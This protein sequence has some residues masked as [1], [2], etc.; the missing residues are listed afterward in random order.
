MKRFI[1]I[2]MCGAMVMAGH[3]SSAK[4]EMPIEGTLPLSYGYGAGYCN[5]Y[6]FGVGAAPYWLGSVPTPPYFALHPPVY[7]SYAV[8][9]TFGHSPFPY[10]GTYRTPEVQPAQPEVIENP[11]VEPEKDN[12][13]LPLENTRMTT[14]QVGVFFNPFVASPAV[15]D[16]PST[17]RYTVTQ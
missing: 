7:Y 10:P 12:E 14:A 8:P 3:V 15:P 9:R 17:A 4:A 6:G 1:G 11:Y 16:R 2:V 13:Q 5:P